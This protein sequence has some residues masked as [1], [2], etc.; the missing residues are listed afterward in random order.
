MLLKDFVPNQYYAYLEMN[1]NRMSGGKMQT[2][3][4]LLA[5][6]RSKGR[7]PALV[8]ILP[9][10]VTIKLVVTCRENSNMV[11]RATIDTVNSYIKNAFIKNVFQ[12]I[13]FLNE[14]LEQSKPSKLLTSYENGLKGIQ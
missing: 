14:E 6:R 4:L 8:S 5:L 13:Y 2:R 7:L 12:N 1:K 3:A 11:G 9:L 10:F